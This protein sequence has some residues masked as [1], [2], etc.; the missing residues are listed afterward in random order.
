[1]LAAES[2][3]E[4][5]AKCF[6]RAAAILRV[7]LRY[8]IAPAICVLFA[9]SIVAAQTV[10][11]TTAAN[12]TFADSL[13][14]AP[15]KRINENELTDQYRYIIGSSV[16]DFG[17]QL[18][19]AGASG[20]ELLFATKIPLRDFEP[21]YEQ[22]SIAAVLKYDG[23]Q[24]FDYKYFA[25]TDPAA[26]ESEMIALGDKGFRYR[27]TF[28]FTDGEKGDTCC[29]KENTAR[30]ASNDSASNFRVGSVVLM[31]RGSGK[32]IKRCYRIL[33]GGTKL[34]VWEKSAIPNLREAFAEAVKT[35]F[36]VGLFFNQ[37]NFRDSIIVEAET[38][39]NAAANQDEMFEYKIVRSE[40]GNKFRGE[41]DEL[42][43]N[44][45]R[46]L[47]KEVNF[48]LMAKSKA[49]AEPVIY[50]LVAADKENYLSE[51]AKLAEQGAVFHLVDFN[52]RGL[53][54][55]EG[56][57]LFERKSKDD[58][59][60]YE[61]T[62]VKITEK[63]AYPQIQRGLCAK[64]RVMPKQTEAPMNE[65]RR[66]VEKGFAPRAMYY[67]DGIIVLFERASSET[68]TQ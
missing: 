18:N 3:T 33:S 49:A 26:A 37:M 8:F 29:T 22:M 39:E 25:S 44:G 64:K 63:P 60:R 66:L 57:L 7:N 4:A 27:K 59:K 52:R 32:Q 67:A 50:A 36:P 17:K 56:K 9:V 40:F 12:K 20:Y 41:V 14:N 10:G 48:A 16:S 6:D 15:P 68:R 5:F 61:Y 31:E 45:W 24:T 38:S 1:M 23:E 65:F 55:Y 46:V 30:C 13:N 34:Y 21:D 54:Y 28:W 53:D 42:T 43:R 51:A 2:K 47:L 58:G 35:S 11:K 62:A 19:E